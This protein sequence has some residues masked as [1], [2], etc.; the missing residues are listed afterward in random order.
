MIAHNPEFVRNLWLELTPMRLVMMPLLLV[1]VFVIAGK[2]SGRD[3]SSANTALTLFLIV[4]VC[5]G[6]KLAADAL[7]D[8]YAQGTWDTQRLSG[9]SAAQMAFGKLFGGPACA[10]Y[11]GLP[12]LLVYA[13]SAPQGAARLS[14]LFSAVALAISLHALCL[15]ATL[16]AARRTPRLSAPRGLLLLLMFVLV[17]WSYGFT[18]RDLALV[19]MPV[20]WYGHDWTPDGFTSFSLACLLGWSVL[21]LYRALREE[22]AFRDAPLAWIGFVLFAWLYAGGFVWNGETPAPLALQLAIAVAISGATTYVLLLIERKDWLRLRRLLAALRERPADPWRIG[23]L[24]P[25]WLCSA[26][27]GVV[28]VLLLALHVVVLPPTPRPVADLATLLA[29]LLFLGRDLALVLALNFTRNPRR[30]D[31]AALLF[32]AVLYGLLPL[33]FGRAELSSLL[34]LW[35]PV[36]IRDTPWMV[37]FVVP[38]TLWAAHFAWRRWQQ[39]PG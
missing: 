3:Y 10:W 14:T 30:A 4:T 19:E 33:L 36:A 12:C 21:G 39:L 34:P 29:L 28:A 11:G 27:L 2:G 31:G 22:L 8:E 15:L 6:S 38:Q 23:A 7:L 5:W 32:F 20:R 25:L 37:V 18:R 35:L 26:L 16:L 1:L 17:S 24:L 13:V 9:L